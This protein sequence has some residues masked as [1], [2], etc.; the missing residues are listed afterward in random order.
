MYSN[1]KEK[2]IRNKGW[3]QEV[4]VNKVKKKN[5]ELLNLRIY[6]KISCL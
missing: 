1:K 4:M 2:K 3:G 6:C 5:Q